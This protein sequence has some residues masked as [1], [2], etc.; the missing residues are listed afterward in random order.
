MNRADA[1]IGFIREIKTDK[2]CVFISHKKEDQ[3]I[4][5]QLGQFLTE[6]LGVDIYLDIFLKQMD[7]H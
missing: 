6:K 4:A 5:V 1:S 7:I 2:T 3:H